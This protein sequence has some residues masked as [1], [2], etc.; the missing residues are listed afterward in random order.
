MNK[1]VTTWAIKLR[2]S[3]KSLDGETEKI[4]G[5]CGRYTVPS[6]RLHGIYGIPAMFNSRAEARAFIED[7]FGYI[8]ER[9]DLQDYPHGWKM[10]I[11]VRITISVE[12]PVGERRGS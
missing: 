5:G 4:M 9:K 1:T 10:P 2:T 12:A 3:D 8:R 6:P 11:P 7:N